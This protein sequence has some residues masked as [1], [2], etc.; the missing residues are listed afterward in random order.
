[1]RDEITRATDARPAERAARISRRGLLGA[2]TAALAGGAGCAHRDISL[3]THDQGRY[4]APIVPGEQLMSQHGILNRTLFIYDT[5]VIRQK[6]TG[7]LDAGALRGAAEIIQQF[8]ERHHEQ[9]EAHYIFIRF[10]LDPKMGPFVRT[11][12]HQHRAGRAVTEQLLALTSGAQLREAA[13]REQAVELLTRFTRMY[14]A[15][16]SREDTVL[17]PEFRKLF[18]AESYAALGEDFARELE[19]HCGADGFAQFVDRV[20]ELERGLGLAD[21]NQFTA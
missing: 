17:F 14:R 2:G 1:M 19:R 13:G 18:T 5:L 20:A 12:A 6:E 7:D 11:L 8:I 9:L 15:H 3:V 4:E 10:E 16:E 21:L